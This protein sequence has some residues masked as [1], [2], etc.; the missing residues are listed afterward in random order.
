MC[1]TPFPTVTSFPVAVFL[2]CCIKAAGECVIAKTSILF[3]QKHWILLKR[4]S[5]AGTSCLLLDHFNHSSLA[6]DQQSHWPSGSSNRSSAFLSR[7]SLALAI[8]PDVCGSYLDLCRAYSF[9]SNVI[10]SDRSF[11]IPTPSVSL[12]TQLFPQSFIICY[13][14]YNMLPL[15][16]PHTMSD[17]WGQGSCLFVHCCNSSTKNSACSPYNYWM[18]E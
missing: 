6:P 14:F 18:V 10:S 16:L 17:A 3:C 4:P 1:N 13:L 2:Y 11:L 9:I 5:C 12:L 7:S 8:S 15:S